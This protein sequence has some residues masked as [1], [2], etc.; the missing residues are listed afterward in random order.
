MHATSVTRPFQHDGWVYEGK[1][2][3]YRMAAQKTDGQCS[4]SAAMAATI[5]VVFPSS[6]GRLLGS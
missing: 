1:V 6:P 3:G 5:P 4:S 2:D